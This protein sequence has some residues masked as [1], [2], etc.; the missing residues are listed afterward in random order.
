MPS[1]TPIP[2]EFSAVTDLWGDAIPAWL[3]AIG[4]IAAAVVAA[5]A[6]IL[7]IRNRGGLRTLTQAAGDRGAAAD[8]GGS[9][10]SNDGAA[11]VSWVAWQEQR[12]RYRLRND[13]RVATAELLS[14]EDVTPDG[15][16]AASTAVSMPLT[17]QPMGS[18]P[19]TIE[20]SLVSPAVTAI[21]LD[22]IENG[23]RK[24]TTIYI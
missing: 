6:I 18:I 14:F 1:P 20:K 13:S 23:E 4:S 7:S 16:G 8:F 21:A 11:R 12:A 2:T 10:S 22:W 5:I 15:D 19:F 9:D 24:S 3:G 17:L